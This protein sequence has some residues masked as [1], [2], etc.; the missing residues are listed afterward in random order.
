MPQLQ[1]TIEIDDSVV[2]GHQHS[3]LARDFGEGDAAIIGR[4]A[5]ANSEVAGHRAE[6]VAVVVK[7]IAAAVR[8]AEAE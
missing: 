3:K 7:A 6:P 5:T 2:E 1:I 8:S 4:I